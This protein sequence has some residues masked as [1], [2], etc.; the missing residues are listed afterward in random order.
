MTTLVYD[1]PDISCDHCRRAIEGAVSPLVGVSSVT[2]DIDRRQVA[3]A[4]GDEGAIR[5]AIEE[6]GYDVST[7][8]AVDDT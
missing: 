2:V 7:V 4:G 8:N 1:V 3:V 6:A 5:V